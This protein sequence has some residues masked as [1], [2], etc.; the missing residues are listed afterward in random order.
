M[1]IEKSL[2]VPVSTAV[3]DT[4]NSLS[5]PRTLLRQEPNDASVPGPSE[6]RRHLGLRAKLVLPYLILALVVGVMAAYL[7]T[8]VV[9]A[10]W[11]ERFHGQLFS[12]ADEAADL[13]VH[14][15]EEQLAAW[16]QIAFTQG[17]AEAVGVGAVANID[18]LVRPIALN[19]QIE[20]LYVF[21]DEGRELF[22]LPDD[23]QT[24]VNGANWP[25]VSQI[26]ADTVNR[27]AALQST[28]EDAYLFTGGALRNET[29][30]MTG[31]LL[32]GLPLADL[33]AQLESAVFA[34]VTLYA[35]DG[36]VLASTIGLSDP[37]DIALTPE[38]V[39]DV[40]AAQE[41]VTSVRQITPAGT[42]YVQVMLPFE[43]QAGQD[44][45]VMGVSL[46][47]DFLISPLYPARNVIMVIF[48]LTVAAT[49]I[50]G[51]LLAGH[52]IRPME[53]LMTAAAQVAAG[54]FNVQ[55]TNHSSDELGQL[56]RSFNDMVIQLHRRRHLEGVF[57][58]YVGDHIARRILL[59][60]ADLGG[61]RV[62][63]TVLFADIRDFTTFTER[64][65][66]AQLIDELNEYYSLM[67][68]AVDA[69]DGVINKFGGDSLL[70]IFGAPLPQE[71]HAEQAVRTATAMMDQ[72][73]LLNARRQARADP[74][75]RIGIGVNTGEMIVGN[76]GAEQRREYTV[77][78]DTVN[79]AKRLSD[80]NK[81]TPTYSIF[82]G[83]NTVEALGKVDEWP[84]DC[85]GEF[86]LK[87]KQNVVATYALIRCEG[88]Q[89]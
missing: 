60:E 74:P 47:Q 55:V 11:S 72:L 31:I 42:P 20:V 23:G 29:N 63:A 40:L 17:V 51:Y 67:Q 36:R 57:G 24:A 58:R 53:Q 45:G 85:L 79:T 89:A 2:H 75:F 62:T 28:G 41:D 46:R 84:F 35:P 6:R 34:D 54:D 14:R 64:A 37:A 65:D 27:Y 39:Q 4:P 7:V 44:V 19:D 80:L 61:R 12:A 78:G 3:E 18:Q 33:A 68:A 76:L 66:L 38:Q 30:T 49:L 26:R 86:S 87:G 21:T 13:I 73:A 16:R 9:L 52:I 32:V 83:E 71:N 70:A 50:I 43:L 88:S 8:R 5:S 59:D 25:I 1:T 77:L 56:T 15:E 82:V 22:R 10:T 69:H 48:T 81:T